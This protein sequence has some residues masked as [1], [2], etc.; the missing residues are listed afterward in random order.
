MQQS[1]KKVMLAVLWSMKRSI[2][3]DFLEEI[4]LP[5]EFPIANSLGNI[6]PNLLNDSYIYVS[7]VLIYSGVLDLF[8][9]NRIP[10]VKNI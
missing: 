6:S 2:T 7:L 8:F 10:R 5:T 3:I 9:L 4:Q 1:V